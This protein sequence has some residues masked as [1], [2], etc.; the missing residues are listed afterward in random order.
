MKIKKILK[1]Y[2][3]RAIYNL[4]TFEKNADLFLMLKV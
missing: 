1:E 3:G 4:F 2:L